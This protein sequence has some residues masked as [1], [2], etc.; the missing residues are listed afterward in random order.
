MAESRAHE[1]NSLYHFELDQDSRIPVVSAVVSK[2]ARRGIITEADLI[3]CNVN[4]LLGTR[5]FGRPTIE[6]IKLI[7]AVCIARSK[8]RQM[9]K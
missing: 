1:P 6:L 2:L 4:G 7:Q 8:S 5:G 3:D 9:R